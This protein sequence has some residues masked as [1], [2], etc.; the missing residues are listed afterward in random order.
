MS[1]RPQPHL[2]SIA[3][4]PVSCIVA[5]LSE[6]LAVAGYRQEKSCRRHWSGSEA[7]W[8]CPHRSERAAF[9]HSAL[10][11][12]GRLSHVGHR[13]PSEAVVRGTA[14]GRAALGTFATSARVRY[15]GVAF[16]TTVA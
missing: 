10:A 11:S 1:N 12:V 15:D 3:K 7:I 8:L 9:P 13:V 16:D 6:N 2:R 5:F 4:T 14:I